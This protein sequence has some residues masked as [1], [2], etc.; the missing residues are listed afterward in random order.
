MGPYPLDPCYDPTK[1]FA[2]SDRTG[3]NDEQPNSRAP[4]L[5]VLAVG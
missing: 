1:P 2:T 5:G 4:P 3:P